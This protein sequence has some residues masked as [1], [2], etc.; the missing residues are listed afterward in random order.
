[1]I[2]KKNFLISDKVCDADAAIFGILSQFICHCRGPLNDFI[3]S[4]N[5]IRI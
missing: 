2:G 3:K 4:I 1:M 5:I